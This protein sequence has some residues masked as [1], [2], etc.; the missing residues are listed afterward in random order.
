MNTTAERRYLLLV[1]GCLAHA[2]FVAVGYFFN[3]FFF[4]G[5]FFSHRLWWA[6][7]VTWPAWAFVLWRYGSKRPGSV[8]LPM[9]I[10][11]LVLS[12]V[13]VRQFMNIWLS[14]SHIGSGTGS[15]H[16]SSTLGG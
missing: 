5:F 3:F 13:L 6:S 11:L 15:I 14:L 16:V 10:G 7:F 8:A 12:P 9:I 1:L 2:A 4:L